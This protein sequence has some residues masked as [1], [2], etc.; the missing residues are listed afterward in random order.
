[1]KETKK[2]ER[3]QYLGTIEESVFSLFQLLSKLNEKRVQYLIKSRT[4]QTGC[5]N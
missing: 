5:V 1:M 4:L 2:E 3:I